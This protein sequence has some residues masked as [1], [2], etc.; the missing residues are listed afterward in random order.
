M[1]GR[2]EYHSYY[3]E[4]FNEVNVKK[5]YDETDIKIINGNYF[6]YKRIIIYIMKEVKFIII[7]KIIIKKIK[8]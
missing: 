8:K 4:N 6:C 3:D 2:K 5:I 1:G 7:K